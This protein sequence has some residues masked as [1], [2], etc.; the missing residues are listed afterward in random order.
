MSKTSNTM[1]NESGESG[2]PCLFLILEEML[3]AFYC[4]VWHKLWAF[5]KWSLWCSHVLLY[6]H[7]ADFFFNHKPML[8]FL[9]S[10][11]CIY[12][13]YHIILTF[14]LLR[15]YITLIVLQILNHPCM[16][17]INPTW[18][19]FLILLM[20]CWIQFANI[21]LR[22]FASMSIRDIGVF[23]VCVWSLFGFGIRV[24][25]AS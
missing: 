13:D 14:H 25:L 23:F 12:W 4:W 10:F 19:S 24:M 2:H 3:S 22:I 1:L 18:S 9:Q 5:H 8:N 20:Y 21:L 11:F 6:T 7:F 16:P 15:W 17:G